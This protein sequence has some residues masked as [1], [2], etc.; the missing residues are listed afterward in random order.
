M[1]DTTMN[2]AVDLLYGVKSIAS[3]LGIKDR[4]AQHLVETKR[5]PHFKIGKTV[6]SR[7]SDIIDAM[8][9]LRDQAEVA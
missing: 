6:C 1:T 3:F 7:R 9:K 4:S 8:D 2:A 5:I